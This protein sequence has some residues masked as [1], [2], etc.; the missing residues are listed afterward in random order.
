MSKR[1]AVALALPLAAAIVAFAGAGPAAAVVPTCDCA[2]VVTGDATP[3]PPDDATA[4]VTT[5]ESAG[6]SDATSVD[7]A[8]VLAA[9]SAPGAD[10]EI[11]S[12][13]TPD[14]AVGLAPDAASLDTT[15]TKECWADQAWDQW[16]TWPYQQKIVD[17]TYWCADYGVKITLRSSSVT[18]GGTIC[19]LSWRASQLIGGGVGFPS[20][21]ERSSAGFSCPTVIPWIV[22]HPSHHLDV[23]RTSVG[24]AS[25]VGKG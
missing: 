17:T 16:G 3:L 1:L 21:T 12:G 11:E 22:L 8:T 6:V 4:L 24:S 10:T 5:G 13:L 19:A 7:P 15:A 20:F 9:A 25:I 18:G 23:L 2:P 14:E